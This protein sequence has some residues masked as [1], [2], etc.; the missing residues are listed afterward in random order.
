MPAT[1]IASLHL[2]ALELQYALAERRRLLDVL[3]VKDRLS[4][5]HAPSV[6][7]IVAILIIL[8]GLIIAAAYLG[9]P[10]APYSP[11]QRC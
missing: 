3:L 4:E 10:G 1:A 11:P 7:A 2:P 5:L 8:L 9:G 6:L